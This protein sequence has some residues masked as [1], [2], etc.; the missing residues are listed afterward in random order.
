MLLPGAGKAAN[1]PPTALLAAVAAAC[2]REVPGLEL[3][4]LGG[5]SDRG[6]I[7]A[8]ARECSVSISLR[9]ELDLADSARLL[10]SAWVVLGGD[11]GPLHLARALGTPV[12]G[13]FHAADPARTGPAG[14]PGASWSEARSGQA[15][16]APCCARRCLRPAGDRIC[17]EAFEAED[18]AARLLPRLRPDRSADEDPRA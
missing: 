16:C 1:Q 13:L 7:E 3:V 11:T 14:I 6:R 2:A 10:A 9:W 15:P 5:P 4:A 12:L 18:L 8:L 17:L